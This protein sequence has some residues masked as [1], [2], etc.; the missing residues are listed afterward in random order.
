MTNKSSDALSR[1]E[2]TQ[3]LVAVPFAQRMQG[4]PRHAR[5]KVDTERVIGE[6]DP[7]IFGIV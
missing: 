5:I 4:S 2:F 1:R 6:I 3:A 7:K